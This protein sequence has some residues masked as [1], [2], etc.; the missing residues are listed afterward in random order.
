MRLILFKSDI[1]MFYKIIKP[2]SLNGMQVV[3]SSKNVENFC[4]NLK[5]QILKN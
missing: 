4:I 5:L 2:T 1:Q 3:T